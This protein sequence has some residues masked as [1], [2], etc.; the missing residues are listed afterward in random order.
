MLLALLADVEEAFRNA[1][2]AGALARGDGLERT[3]AFWAVLQ[4]ALSLEKARR[5]AP[6]LPDAARVGMAAVTAMLAGW[7]AD[8]SAIARAERLVSTCLDA[9][10][11]TT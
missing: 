9:K 7:G 5:L 11:G 8:A 4:G 6:A 3:L 1:A 10:K 2:K